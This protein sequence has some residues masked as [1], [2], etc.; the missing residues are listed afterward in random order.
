MLERKCQKGAAR[1]IYS[2]NQTTYILK[3]VKR[4]NLWQD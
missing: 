2:E 1:K 4:D 3:K